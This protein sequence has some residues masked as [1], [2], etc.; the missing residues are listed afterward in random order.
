MILDH[1]I[2]FADESAY[3][4]AATPTRFFEFNS[5]G[6]EEA[7][8]RTEGDP[9]RVGTHVRRSDRFTPWFSGAAGTIQ[10]DVLTKGFGFFL[11]HMLGAVATT[12][13]AETTVYTHTGTMGDLWGD[14][15]TCQIGRPLNPG[16]TV[17]PFTY[18]GG[19]VTEWTLSNTVD[20][21]LL[22]ELGVDFQQ[23]ATDTAL[24]TASYP[25]GMDNLT[26]AGAVVTVGGSQFD[27]SD[28]S[29]RGN[30]NLNVD[31]RF[32][33]GSTD[34][35]EP[36]SSRRELE[37]TLSADFESMTQRNRAHAEAKADALAEIVA[38]WTGPTLLGSTLYPK[39]V[40]TL[41]AGRFDAW[42]GAAD[43]PDGITQELSGV[44]L[45]DGTNSPVTIAYSSADT[46][47]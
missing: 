19:K 12:G 2:G 40:V 36:V 45:F 21:N 14:S 26:W 17:Q 46:T 27:V 28:I 39:L 13:P 32:L 3:G 9:L 41:P 24:A 30:N 11:K 37:F 31:R 16:G 1:Q 15:F 23:V 47:A 34:K 42:S 43:G 8:G 5:E 10:M 7:E 18:R 29:V 25:S 44:G 38:T 35:K 20:A 6:I 33:S 22:L 4:T